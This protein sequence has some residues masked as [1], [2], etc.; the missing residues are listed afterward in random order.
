[1]Y[2]TFYTASIPY[3]GE[4]FTKPDKGQNHES[5]QLIVKELK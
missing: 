5:Q 2:D 1:M 4:K 3:H